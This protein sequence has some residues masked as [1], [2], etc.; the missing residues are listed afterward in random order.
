MTRKEQRDNLLK[1]ATAIVNGAK[2]SNRDLTADEAT[3]VAAKIAEVRGIKPGV[4]IH[5]T[6]VAVTGQGNS[7]GLF[8]VLGLIG[9]DRVV[10]RLAA[11]CV[12]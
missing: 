10:D 11:R 7:P 9:R 2:A 5:A 3:D 4:L 1:A 8:E 6:R 12:G